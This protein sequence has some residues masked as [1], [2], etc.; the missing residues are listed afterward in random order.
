MPTGVQDILAANRMRPIDGSV[1][2]P[3][4]LE[5]RS[6]QIQLRLLVEGLLDDCLQQS[7]GWLL[8]PVCGWLAK[9]GLQKAA[10]RARQHLAA[11][12]DCETARQVLVH[13][14][15]R[16]PSDEAP[17]VLHVAFPEA[18]LSEW[19]T[20]SPFRTGHPTWQTR[21]LGQQRAVV[22]GRGDEPCPRCS[23]PVESLLVVS[24]VDAKAVSARQSAQFAWCASCSPF[25]TA[26][27]ARVDAAGRAQ[28]IRPE[29]MIEIGAMY[30]AP[31]PFPTTEVGLVDVGPEWRTQNWM[32]SNNVE[33]L[34]RV[35]GL[36]TWIQHEASPDCLECHRQMAFVA[37]IAVEDLWDGEGIVY[38]HWCDDCAVTGA[39]YQQT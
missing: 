7:A 14:G 23:G 3:A 38:L 35:G 39:V 21:A 32:W 37:Q 27:Y 24:A 11:H 19:R 31:Q 16:D 22:G 25:T 30:D 33:N 28:L 34:H 5:I 6:D 17:P 8:P 15:L 1:V 20:R 12:D 9:E 10:E 18:V 13:F 29:P 4:L 26:T 36:P 2:R